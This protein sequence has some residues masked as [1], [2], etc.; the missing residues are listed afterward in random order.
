MGCY[1]CS[2]EVHIQ[3][4]PQAPFK[5]YLEQ[6]TETFLASVSLSAVWVIA[7]LTSQGFCKDRRSERKSHIEAARGTDSSTVG[8][9]CYSVKRRAVPTLV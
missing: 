6:V 7:V 9:I 1:V 5:G 3:I 4:L 8:L 2:S